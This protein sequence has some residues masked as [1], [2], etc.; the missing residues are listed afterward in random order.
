[1][2]KQLHLFPSFPYGSVTTEV[3]EQ[4]SAFSL[5]QE[6]GI[7][8]CK[9]RETTRE[10]TTEGEKWLKEAWGDCGVLLCELN[11]HKSCFSETGRVSFFL[12]VHSDKHMRKSLL[13]FPQNLRTD[14]LKPVA[15]CSVIGWSPCSCVGHA[16]KACGR[17]R[18]EF[19]FSRG[20]WAGRGTFCLL[21]LDVLS[22]LIL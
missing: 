5:F 14:W 21:L 13:C 15:K 22:V 8:L 11:W 4:N 16:H 10:V 19:C 7:W 6:R 18:E 12:S 9:G 1:M 3:T 2:S 20:S 17:L